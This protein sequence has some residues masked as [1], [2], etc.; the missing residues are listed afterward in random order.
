MNTFTMPNSDIELGDY[1]ARMSTEWTNIVW[2]ITHQCQLGCPYCVGWKS[3]TPMLTLID[4][5]GGVS[6]AVDRF[7]LLR[8]KAK[9]NFYITIS[10]GEP[11]LVKDLPKLCGELTKRGFVVELQTNLTT[12]YVKP[13]VDSVNPKNIGQIVATYHGWKL[14]SSA[15]AQDLYF[16]N[17][18]YAVK[19]GITCILKTVVIPKEI[20]VFAAKLALL[21][22][23]MPEEGIVLPWVYI[24]GHPNSAIDS[25][26][27]Y[28]QA[29][30][31][32]EGNILDSITPCRRVC[33]R[34]YRNGA[35]FFNGMLC[36]AGRGFVYM[37]IDGNIHTCYSQKSG[38]NVLGSFLSGNLTLHNNPEPC[39]VGYCGT[40]FWGLWFG[41]NPW[42]Y[43]PG[44]DKD[45]TYYC[46]FGNKVQCAC[47]YIS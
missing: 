9:K 39:G 18:S 43:V 23:K 35:G 19:Q 14:D 7:E 2:I 47:P 15:P 41:V 36:D 34:M 13:F 22:K 32:K 5:I 6:N 29:Y 11:T 44:A 8:A 3:K 4:K 30:T 17:F 20:K 24:S 16:N 27:A 45:S 12:S 33:Q 21:K 37:D 42:D 10:G 26:G 25:N 1:P 40:P 38:R 28:P 31:Q 46:R